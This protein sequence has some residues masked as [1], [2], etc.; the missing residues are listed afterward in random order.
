MG[1]SLISPSHRTVCI[2][3][4]ETLAKE[5]S[6]YDMAWALHPLV[7]ELPDR[8]RLID[9]VVTGMQEALVRPQPTGRRRKT[10]KKG[11]QDV[12]DGEPFALGERAAAAATRQGSQPDG[13]SG[14]GADAPAP[15]DGSG[16]PSWTS[17]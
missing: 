14:G 16:S 3:T 15:G 4:N 9:H 13:A 17:C 7:W 2:V 12:P 11:E 1:P 10:K 8:N 6:E 5:V